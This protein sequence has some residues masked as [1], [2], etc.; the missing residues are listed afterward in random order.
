[1]GFLKNSAVPTANC[2]MFQCGPSGKCQTVTEP[3]AT[4]GVVSVVIKRTPER[5]QSRVSIRFYY[6]LYASFFSLLKDLFEYIKKVAI[7]EAIIPKTPND[8]NPNCF[9]I[10]IPNVGAEVLA[11]D[12]AEFDRP[13][14]RPCCSCEATVLIRES[15][16]V[17]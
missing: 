11:T 6:C 5:L 14:I 9:V 13:K 1:M 15:A 17:P 3:V 8:P 4:D 7:S 2:V 12:M 10:H 16:L